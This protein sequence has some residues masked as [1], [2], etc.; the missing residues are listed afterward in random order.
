MER[1]S[2]ETPSLG[3]LLW[4]SASGHCPYAPP[5]HQGHS[6]LWENSGDILVDSV[7]KPPN[8]EFAQP[9]SASPHTHPGAVSLVLEVATPAQLL[10]RP[11]PPPFPMA[12]QSLSTRPTRGTCQPEPLHPI[13]Q[14]LSPILDWEGATPGSALRSRGEQGVG[15]D[16]SCGTPLAFAFSRP[17]QK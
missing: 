3:T 16:A 14:Q 15:R 1:R 2:P 17:V 12:D 10:P 5:I 13:P 9:P 4:P 11:G 6:R 8:W 7:I